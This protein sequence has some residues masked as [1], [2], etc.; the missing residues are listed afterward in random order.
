MFKYLLNL[1]SFLLRKY[2]C[3]KISFSLTSIDLLVSY[4]FKSKKKGVYVDVGCN[5]PVYSN[6]TY[7]LYKKGWR[8]INIDLD[9]KSIDLFNTYRNDDFNLEAAV[10]SKVEDV[11]LY[12][13]HDKSPINTINKNLLQIENLNT[14][15]N[16]SIYKLF[17]YCLR[18][19]IYEQKKRIYNILIILYISYKLFYDNPNSNSTLNEH[20]VYFEKNFKIIELIDNSNIL[21]N[22]GNTIRSSMFGE[23]VNKDFLYKFLSF[24]IKYSEEDKQIHLSYFIKKHGLEGRIPNYKNDLLMINYQYKNL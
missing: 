13:F 8:G 11:E 1:P 14:S 15:S 21:D 10:S 6:N 17:I 5:H 3:R 23:K 16:D 9:K 2:K 18:K 24:L 12:F 22:E 7:L 4:I 19:I 20:R